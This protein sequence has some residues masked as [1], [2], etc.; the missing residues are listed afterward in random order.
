MY[1][2][3]RSVSATRSELDE[4]RASREGLAPSVRLDMRAGAI[5][6]AP[7]SVPPTPSRDRGSCQRV[8][9]CHNTGYVPVGTSILTQPPRTAQDGAHGAKPCLDIQTIPERG[10]RASERRTGRER[11]ICELEAIRR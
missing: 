7:F 2:G 8:R 4:L 10:K 9:V 3:A 6:G 5:E 1:R 11:D